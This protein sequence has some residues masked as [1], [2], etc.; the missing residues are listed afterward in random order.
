MIRRSLGPNSIGSPKSS[1][2]TLQKLTELFFMTILSSWKTLQNNVFNFL[3]QAFEGFFVRIF[4]SLLNWTPDAQEFLLN[5]AM[6][7]PNKA[8]CAPDSFHMPT[9]RPT[10]RT[11]GGGMATLHPLGKF[12]MQSVT[13]FIR[14]NREGPSWKGGRDGGRNTAWPLTTRFDEKSEQL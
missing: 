5:R 1:W 10:D 12:L 4:M 13:H 6:P 7:S 9:D 14:W 11:R 3:L 2:K 8:P